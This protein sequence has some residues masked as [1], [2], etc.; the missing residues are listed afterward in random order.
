MQSYLKAQHK[1]F[2]R[3]VSRAISTPR[4]SA[5]R[6]PR[7]CEGAV[8]RSLAF[9][10]SRGTEVIHR[11]LR[12]AAVAVGAGVAAFSA[13]QNC[14]ASEEPLTFGFY[15]DFAPVSYSE[16][17][18]AG[19]P[20]YHEHRGYE[21]DLVTALEALE[22]ASL[23]FRR[24][25]I[26][27][28]AEQT[29]P[30]WLL[31]ATPEFDV[32]G[33]GITIRDDRTLGADGETAIRF[34]SGHI[35]FRQSMLVRSADAERLRD[36]AALTEDVK[37][38]VIGG[39]TGEA[40]LLQ[41]AGYADED[42][43]LKAGTGIEAVADGTAKFRVTPA[44][45]QADPAGWR[46]LS[47]P[48]ASSPQIIYLEHERAQLAALEDGS[49]DVVA[50]GEIGNADAASDGRFVITGVDA[51]AR[52][53]G[54]FAVDV[55]DS[56]LLACLNERIPWLTAAGRIAYPEW[57]QNADVFMQRAELWNDMRQA[58]RQDGQV[59]RNAGVLF[60]A[61]A[62]SLRYQASSSDPGV[63]TAQVVDGVLT[64]R[65]HEDGEGV[66]TITLTATAPDG[67][68][69]AF[70]F[71]ITGSATPQAFLRGWRWVLAEE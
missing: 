27:Y 64:V 28:W 46:R 40:R 34:T 59:T 2:L 63:A 30:I 36:Y 47:P 68:S 33:G 69:V 48:D 50:R 20:G 71:D 62:S 6:W 42:G 23:K 24:R 49:I 15:F 17:R 41:L 39:T 37:V 9:K 4:F 5:S 7:S 1:L 12:G 32:V 56:S 65:V 57:R 25:A 22:D 14:V 10:S 66:A 3:R 13:A 61:G 53:Q 70:S 44:I 52:E 8:L 54:G 18:Q 43:V 21:A 11:V 19:Q 55:D 16:N 60:A 31:A 51:E 67:S 38:G 45:R 29:P 35:S 58:L 26:G